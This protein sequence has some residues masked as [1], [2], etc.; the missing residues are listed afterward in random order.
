MAHGVMSSSCDS[1]AAAPTRSSH[2]S[3]IFARQDTA[4]FEPS[5][6]GCLCDDEL[7][8]LRQAFERYG[9]GDGFWMTFDEVIEQAIFYPACNRKIVVGEVRAAFREWASDDAQFLWTPLY[10][11]P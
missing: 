4:P 6:C 11:T 3:H 8:R 10:S 2:P 5:R 7:S 1:W 9:A